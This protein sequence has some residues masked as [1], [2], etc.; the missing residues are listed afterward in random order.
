MVTSEIENGVQTTNILSNNLGAKVT[1]FGIGGIYVAMT[2]LAGRSMTPTQRHW[3]L[4]L[5]TT[6]SS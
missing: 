3:G 5:M 4:T 1:K 6:A 2:I